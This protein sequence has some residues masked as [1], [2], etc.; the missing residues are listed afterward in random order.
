ME[1]RR[2]KEEKKEK[3]GKKEDAKNEENPGKKEEINDAEKEKKNEPK[4]KENANKYNLETNGIYVEN[5]PV[6]SYNTANYEK[7]ALEKC[8]LFCELSRFPSTH[9]WKLGILFL[10]PTL[11]L[12]WPIIVHLSLRPHVSDKV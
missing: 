7:V 5:C 4:D 1:K 8:F 11:I 10:R 12:Y 2:K 6:P 9:N 3:R